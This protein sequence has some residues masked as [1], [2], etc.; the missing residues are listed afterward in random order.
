MKVKLALLSILAFN[1]GK[2]F[3]FVTARLLKSDYPILVAINEDLRNQGSLWAIG[4]VPKDPCNNLSWHDEWSDVPDSDEWSDAPVV[5]CERG[6]A[7]G[8]NLRFC[9]L[10]HIP[11]AVFNLLTLSKF[12]LLSCIFLCPF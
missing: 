10:R 9:G 11:P 7:T 4:K 8:V 12:H 5:E 1:P 3:E 6:K 2:E